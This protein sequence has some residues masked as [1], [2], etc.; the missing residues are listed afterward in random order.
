MKKTWPLL[1]VPF[2]F[3]LL[4][5]S[6]QAPQDDPAVKADL[7]QV[8][9]MCQLQYLDASGKSVTVPARSMLELRLLD[10]STQGMRIEIY[11]EN[12]DYSQVD[13]RSFHIVRA[14]GDVQEVRLVR[15]KMTRMKFPLMR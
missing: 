13:A 11:Y 6:P 2:A 7:A 15:S 10:D 9:S 4:A 5:M 1:A 3:L 8:V 12:G 14:G